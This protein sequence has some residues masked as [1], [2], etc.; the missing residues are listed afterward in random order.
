MVPKKGRPKPPVKKKPDGPKARLYLTEQ[1]VNK[2]IAAAKSVGRLGHRDSTMILLAFRHG[3]R[4]TEVCHL[5]WDQIR[6]EIDAID[7]PH[8]AVARVDRDPG[9]IEAHELAVAQSV[10]HVLSELVV[11]T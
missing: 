6:L 10:V 4:C 7:G 3:M 2:L 5:Q 11:R 9:P 8:D 1:E